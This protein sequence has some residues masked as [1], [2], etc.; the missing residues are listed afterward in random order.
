MSEMA[1]HSI[2]DSSQPLRRRAEVI[3][4]L[5]VA[6]RTSNHCPDICVHVRKALT[7]EFEPIFRVLSIRHT[8]TVAAL[9]SLTSVL[10]VVNVPARMELHS[11]RTAVASGACKWSV[12]WPTGTNRNQPNP[13]ETNRANRTR[14]GLDRHTHTDTHGHACA[15]APLSACSDRPQLH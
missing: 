12:K 10:Q 13:T 3:A 7:V 4:F 11:Q 5:I 1:S 14:K 15:R 8:L 6:R 9:P 2:S